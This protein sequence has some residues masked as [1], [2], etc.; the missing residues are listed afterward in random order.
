[1]LA[2]VVVDQEFNPA[3]GQTKENEIGICCFSA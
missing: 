2:L 1:M 3:S